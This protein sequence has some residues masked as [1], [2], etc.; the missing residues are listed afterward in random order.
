M[1]IDSSVIIVSDLNLR[2]LFATEKLDN[3]RVNKKTQLEFV[4][5]NETDDCLSK[6][7]SK[8]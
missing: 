5:N 2:H 1:S 7:A 6:Y 4:Y 3:L 8:L